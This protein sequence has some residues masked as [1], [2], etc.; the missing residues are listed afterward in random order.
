MTLSDLLDERTRADY[1]ARYPHGW[2]ASWEPE[3][4]V[5][6]FVMPKAE[7]GKEEKHDTSH[8]T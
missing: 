8:N 2:R 3:G 1:D 4:I 7:K 6:R 5:I